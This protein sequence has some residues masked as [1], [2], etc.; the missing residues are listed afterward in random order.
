MQTLL[1]IVF[2][3][4]QLAMHKYFIFVTISTL[5]W[6]TPWQWAQLE[7]NITIFIE[8]LGYK[9]N[10]IKEFQPSNYS[11]VKERDFRGLRLLSIWIKV[12]IK[13]DDFIYLFYF[14]KL[15]LV[16]NTKLNDS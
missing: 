13:R 9:P 10:K 15:N 1:S 3:F 2:P 12:F 11:V 16:D 14:N 7:I 6:G 4:I 8:R 5:T